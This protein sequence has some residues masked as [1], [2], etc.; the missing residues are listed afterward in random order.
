[1]KNR[2]DEFT[3][4]VRSIFTGVAML[5][6]HLIHR[7]THNH[8]RRRVKYVIANEYSIADKH[9]V[10]DNH[11]VAPHRSVNLRE[12]SVKQIARRHKRAARLNLRSR[13]NI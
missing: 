1:M 5:L 10:A 2:K 4:A 11:S 8:R 9:S 12:V 13:T 7:V 3:L 6:H